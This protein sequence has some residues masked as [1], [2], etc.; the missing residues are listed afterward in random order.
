MYLSKR[1]GLLGVWCDE[2]RRGLLGLLLSKEEV[3]LCSSDSAWS[4]S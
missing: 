3:Q 4:S 2:E 1:E